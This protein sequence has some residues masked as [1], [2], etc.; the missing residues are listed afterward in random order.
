MILDRYLKK[1]KVN[2]YLDLNDEERETYRKWELALSGRRLTDED[3]EL[4]FRNEVEDTLVKLV[5]TKTDTKNDR[6][7]KVKLD[8][9]RKVQ[10]FLKAPEMERKQLEGQI[11]GMIE[12]M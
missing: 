8:F 4:F 9:L 5:D 12:R 7:L 3:T 11:A 10:T 6:F 1:L 2:S